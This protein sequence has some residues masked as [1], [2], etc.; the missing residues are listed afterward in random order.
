[1][2]SRCWV[3]GLIAIALSLGYLAREES[4]AQ[5]LEQELERPAWGREIPAD[6]RFVLIFDNSAVWDRETDLIW[7][8]QPD[9]LL[10]TWVEAQEFCTTRSL[11]NRLGWRL[12]RIQELASLVDTRR[13]SPALPPGHPFLGIQ[14]S[15]SYWSATASLR[16]IN[17]AWTITFFDSGTFFV[18]GGPLPSPAIVSTNRG[19]W[20][21]RSFIPGAD[22]Q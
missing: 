15:T 21:V 3:I 14:P 11:G 10:R 18:G 9:P 4:T 12:P 5:T 8:R 17:S 2:K 16:D 13:S 6:Q 7:E 22:S 1:M 20:C 19:A